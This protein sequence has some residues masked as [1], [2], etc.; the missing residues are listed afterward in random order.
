[1]DERTAFKLMIEAIKKSEKVK[2]TDSME[3][4]IIRD[5]DKK[6]TILPEQELKKLM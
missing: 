6:F 1:M 2:D 4:A 3:I 5:V